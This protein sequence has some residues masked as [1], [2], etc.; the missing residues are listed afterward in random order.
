MPRSGIYS[1]VVR[2]RRLVSLLLLLQFGRG[3]PPEERARRLRTSRRSVHRD[4]EA[5]REAGVPVQATRGPGGGFRLPD[6]YRSRLPLTEEEATALLVGGAAAASAL[7][8]DPVLL[9]AR[10]KLIG[11]LATDVRE[12]AGRAAQLIHVDEP[13][14][15][16]TSDEPPFLREVAAA[17]ADRRRLVVTYQ[18]GRG[19]TVAPVLDPLG[20]VLK[21]GVWYLVGRSAD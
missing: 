12:R 17:A 6:G 10:L 14:W 16:H 20:L 4:I 1:V 8:L 3:W 5:L 9:E 15:F 13:P 19:G 2:A 11:A 7:G 21:A 18:A